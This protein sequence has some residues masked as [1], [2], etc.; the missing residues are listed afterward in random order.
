MAPRSCSRV[1]CSHDA[2]F[3]L[4]YVYRDR[5]AVIGPLSPTVDPHSYD[6]CADCADFLTVPKGWT[7]MRPVPEDE[8]RRQPVW[9]DALLGSAE[10]DLEPSRPVLI[11]DRGR[12]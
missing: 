6:L 8:S 2:E 9:A 3:T 10:G 5:M 11:T 12:V 7:V 1:S 4:S